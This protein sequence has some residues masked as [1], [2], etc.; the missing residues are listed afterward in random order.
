VAGMPGS[1]MGAPDSREQF[2]I[3]MDSTFMDVSGDG[4]SMRAQPPQAAER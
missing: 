3:W 2:M 4:S 1:P